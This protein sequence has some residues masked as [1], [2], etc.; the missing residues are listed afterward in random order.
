MN[1]HL[2]KK[3]ELS[4]SLMNYKNRKEF[5]TRIR[6]VSQVYFFILVK[7]KIMEI[8][9][10]MLTT[11]QVGELLNVHRNTVQMYRECGILQGIKT[12]KNYM[13]SQ[14]EISEFQERFRGYDISNKFRVKESLEMMKLRNEL[15]E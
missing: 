2:M 3:K 1:F 5:R 8:N 10:Q 14:K 15:N 4:L 7:K 13:F 11:D 6:N 12:G 9:L